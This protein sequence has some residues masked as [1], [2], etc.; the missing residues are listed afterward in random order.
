M[1]F[2]GPALGAKR[3]L[4]ERSRSVALAVKV[5]S[6]GSLELLHKLRDSVVYKRRNQEVEPI[7]QEGIGTDGDQRSHAR[8]LEDRTFAI[9]GKKVGSSRRI[10]VV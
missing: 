7:G 5:H 10:F 2:V 9:V 1:W 4:K 3:P 6:V 8:T